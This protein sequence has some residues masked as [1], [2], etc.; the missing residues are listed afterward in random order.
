M[1]PIVA[2]LLF[3][4]LDVQGSLAA[5]SG[6][7]SQRPLAPVSLNIT[8]ASTMT[9]A[10]V[11]GPTATFGARALVVPMGLVALDPTGEQR[12]AQRR[13]RTNTGSSSNSSGATGAA[14]ATGASASGAQGASATSGAPSTTAAAEEQADASSGAAE[15]AGSSETAAPA[16]A[17][18]PAEPAGP[19]GPAEADGSASD[20][21]NIELIQHRQQNVNLHRPLGIATFATL[22]V[23]E[24][25]GIFAAINQRTWFGQGECRAGG[26]PI[27]GFE[28]G[29][30]GLS[31]LHGVF[32]FATITLY[33][34]TGIYA[35]SM[36]DPERA[37]EGSSRGAVRLRIHKALAWVH[38][39]GMVAMPVLGF[40]GANPNAFGIQDTRG[41]Y[42]AAFRSVHEI[43]GFVTWGALGAAMVVEL[44]P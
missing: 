34:T 4:T 33:T 3:A 31:A 24:V 20:E 23:T 43:L 15:S 14:N 13:R 9:V 18:G 22:T 44:I 17:A 10:G 28:F 37:S 41:D 26:S 40:L 21:P 36:P 25:L 27:L 38:A 19:A 30:N 12:L 6:T 32:A 2:G 1:Q 5:P 35:L 39:I 29:C 16:E 8:G 42:A 11:P 7:L